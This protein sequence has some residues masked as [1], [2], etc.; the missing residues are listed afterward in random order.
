MYSYL[1]R[2]GLLFGLDVAGLFAAYN[3]AHKLR[4]GEWPSP[5]EGSLWILV[6][7]AILALYVMDMYRIDNSRD[8]IR[9]SLDAFVAVFV[10]AAASVFIVYVLGVGNF[11]PIFGRGVL[12]V[13]LVIF[14]IWAPL[15]R[16][17]L[18]NWYQ[19]TSGILHWLMIGSEESF[20]YFNQDMQEAAR[21][22]QPVSRVTWLSA[23][24]PLH[25]IESWIE[26]HP[27]RAGI[28]LDSQAELGPRL[29]RQITE[30]EKPV[31]VLTI[32]QYYEQYWKKLSVANI[33][34][35]WLRSDTRNLLHK[36][37]AFRIKRLFDCLIAV[38]ALIVAAPLMLLVGMLIYVHS[39]GKVIYQQ[40]RVGLNE[41]VFTLYKFRSMINDAEKS[42]VQWSDV[43]DPRITGFGKFLRA[44]RI[45]ELPQLWNLI[46][47]NMSLIGPRPERPEF[48]SWL[49][50]EIPYYQ[51]RHS[52]PP[53][54]TGWAQVKYPY[55][56]S[57][58]DA[59]HKLEYDLYYIKH[60]SIKLDIVIILKTIMV[61]LK[62]RGR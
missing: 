51:M 15:S 59:R 27:S 33:G 5:L 4:F 14:S 16:W 9:L 22:T 1:T 52:V 60:H 23:Q 46:L 21:R 24:T 58:E 25:R 6:T 28:I 26:D 44:A 42:G 43:D 50:K 20:A 18:A 31:S 3:L 37:T 38:M 11:K 36:Q 57:V 19:S 2:T 56:S 32:A 41:R 10:I 45:D 55:G 35:D 8:P 13:A 54:I 29:I 17:F 12:P 62:G 53:G 39:P 30:L 40:K 48:V 47:G 34:E 7:I 61:I 49:K